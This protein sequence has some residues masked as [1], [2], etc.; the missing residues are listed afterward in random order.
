MFGPIFAAQLMDHIAPEGL[1]AF[2][3]IVHLLLALYTLYR[4]T[5]RQAP[6]RAERESFQGLP[7]PK[8]AT[9]ESAILDPRAPAEEAAA[10]S[11]N[12]AG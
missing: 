3:A 8:T 12:P 9:P 5:R 2:C 6:L 4:M 10:E 11:K 7:V 1:F